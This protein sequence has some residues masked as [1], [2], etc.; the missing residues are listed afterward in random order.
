MR[1]SRYID[2]GEWLFSSV[3]TVECSFLCVCQLLREVSECRKDVLDKTARTEKMSSRRVKGPLD[4]SP[5][6][7]S[8]PCAPSVTLFT[9]MFNPKSPFANNYFYAWTIGLTSISLKNENSMSRTELCDHF[10][11]QACIITQPERRLV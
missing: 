5:P 4:S 11:E 8:R 2:Y 9:N 10:T 1:N 7:K 6:A 3:I